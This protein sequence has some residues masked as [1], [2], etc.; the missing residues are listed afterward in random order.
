MSLNLPDLRRIWQDMW[1]TKKDAAR[2]FCR[3]S[4]S[5][6]VYSDERRLQKAVDEGDVRTKTHGERVTYNAWDCIKLCNLL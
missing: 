3:M 2:Y 5:G 6:K 4:Y 1:L